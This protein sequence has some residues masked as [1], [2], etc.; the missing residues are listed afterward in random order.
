MFETSSETITGT[1]GAEASWDFVDGAGKDA[2]FCTFNGT[3]AAG[4][5]SDSPRLGFCGVLEPVDDVLASGGLTAVAVAVRSGLP[6][7]GSCERDGESEWPEVPRY[8][9]AY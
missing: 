6:L 4:A 1:G 2:F 7:R 3:V 5:G 8:F 9:W